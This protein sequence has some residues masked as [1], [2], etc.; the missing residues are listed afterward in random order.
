MKMTRL[1]SIWQDLSCYNTTDIVGLVS[2]PE[3]IRN[4]FPRG[5]SS[6][7]SRVVREVADRK[8][9]TPS[10]GLS[11]R[12]GGQ[13]CRIRKQWLCHRTELVAISR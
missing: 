13:R 10:L 7:P 2:K 1:T 5:R 3:Q 9:E 6:C 8:R 12:T 11:F 4:S